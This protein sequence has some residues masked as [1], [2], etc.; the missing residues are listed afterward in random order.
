M[1]AVAAAPACAL[2]PPN[3]AVSVPAETKDRG[4]TMTSEDERDYLYVVVRVPKSGSTSLQRMVRD[5]L[6][7][8][9]IFS[10]PDEQKLGL[11]WNL[12]A[13]IANGLTIWR[14]LVLPYGRLT[15]GGALEKI[16][17]TA[18]RGD[19]LDGHVSA[20][21]IELPGWRQR[22]ITLLRAPVDRLY[23]EYNYARRGYEKFSRWRKA[24]N[25]GHRRVAAKGSFED[26]VAWVYERRAQY[27]DSAARMVIGAAEIDRAEAL[28]DEMYFQHGVVERMD[29]FAE[30]LS[31]KL[32]VAIAPQKLNTTAPAERPALSATAR[33]RIEEMFA[34]DLALHAHATRR[35]L[36]EARVS[37]AV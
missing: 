11:R 36:A 15:L 14:R 4:G 24:T 31:R 10:L 13:T 9:K 3:G 25:F 28:L 20:D 2:P 37:T 33:S 18:R 19:I 21:R 23:S 7:G 34:R 26:Y 32:G 35:A 30:Q 29:L 5:A 12:D 6:P 27:A 8:A 22:R 16:A 17:R 1:R